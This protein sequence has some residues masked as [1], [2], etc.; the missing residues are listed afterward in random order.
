MIEGIGF[1][2]GLH[3]L[4]CRVKTADFRGQ[5]VPIEHSSKVEKLVS[6]HN[7]EKKMNLYVFRE[8]PNVDIATLPGSH[9]DDESGSTRNKRYTISGYHFIPKSRTH[10]TINTDLNTYYP[11]HILMHA[12]TNQ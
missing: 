1:H 6:M 4:Y 7:N 8:K 11:G 12:L 5:L 2:A 9:L 3:Y 10:Y